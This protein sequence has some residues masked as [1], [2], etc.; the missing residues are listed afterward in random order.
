MPDVQQL[1]FTEQGTG[2]PLL[3]L[4]GLFGAGNNW[5]QIGKELSKQHRIIQVDLR[6]HGQS[7]HNDRMDY[8]TMANDVLALMDHLG[9]PT[10]IVLG[11]SMGGKVAMELALQHPDRCQ[12]LIVVDIA[13]VAYEP[14]HGDVFRGIRSVDLSGLQ[15]RKDAQEQLATFISDKIVVQFLM[16]SLYRTET[17]FQWRFNAV[18][19]EAAY[20]ALIAAPTAT[21]AFEGPVLFIKGTQSDY[22]LATHKDRINALFPHAQARLIQDSG[23]WPHAEKPRLLLLQVGQFIA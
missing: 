4:H 11:H 9:L 15:H 17:G 7:F 18:A 2:Q 5:N 19:L 14:R 21:T 22:I 23:H 8:P 6:N 13:P 12:K 20:P 10:A 16:K 3:I 1:H